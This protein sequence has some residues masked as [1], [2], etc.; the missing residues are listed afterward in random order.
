MQPGS[1][2]LDPV[3]Q[4]TVSLAGLD[5][6][7][8][9]RRAPSPSSYSWVSS[10]RPSLAACEP[11]VDEP[12]LGPFD[13][14][15]AGYPV[16]LDLEEQAISAV[17]AEQLAALPLPFLES[18]RSKLRA[19]DRAW[20]G[21][22]RVGRA[23]RAGVLAARRLEGAYLRDSSPS[24]PFKNSYYIVLRGAGGSSGFWTSSYQEFIDRVRLHPH[25]S[26]LSPEAICHG[27]PT[28]AESEA[29]LAGARTPWPPVL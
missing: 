3:E 13:R 18:A 1:S 7:I 21:A 19:V 24:I 6:T 14:P 23:F 5:I 11:R 2:S 29:F 25:R 10:V 16:S 26:E 15:C 4:V 20:T 28:R 22:A 12:E 17:T 27:F 8:S 9:V